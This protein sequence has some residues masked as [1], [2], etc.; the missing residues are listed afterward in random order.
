V[1]FQ[2][3]ASVIQAEIIFQAINWLLF[4]YIPEQ[5]RNP[6]GS[7][8]DKTHLHNNPEYETTAHFMH[9]NY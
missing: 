2:Q 4:F 8:C 9:V 5:K 1:R 3:Y 6:L 7:K